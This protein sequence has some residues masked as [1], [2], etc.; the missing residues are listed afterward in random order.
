MQIIA[1]NQQQ[2]NGITVQTV[3]ARELHAWLESKQE[4][5]NWIKQR[6]EQYAFVEGADF[7]VDKF[8]NGKATQKDYHISLDMAKELSMVE[9]NENGKQARQYFI[10]CERK[11]KTLTPAQLLLAQAQQ[12]VEMELRQSAVEEK[13]K[14]IE[15]NL[16]RE[17]DFFTIIGFSRYI[18]AIIDN[19]TANAMGRKAAKLSRERNIP[20]GTTADP[21]YGRVNTYHAD[22]LDEVFEEFATA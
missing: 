17:Q 5:A 20:V 15:A 2:I 14:Q 7:T 11:V 8:I 9:R 1:I 19:T 12:M 18:D 4:F 10:E 21:R 6:I 22:I 13:I 16:P 3:N